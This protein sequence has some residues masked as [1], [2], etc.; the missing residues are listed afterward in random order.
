MASTSGSG[1][2]WRRLCFMMSDQV[3]VD[4]KHASASNQDRSG[5][6]PYETAPARR[7]R[8]GPGVG[9]G[10]PVGVRVCVHEEPAEIDAWV[11]DGP[12]LPVDECPDGGS[13]GKH[14]AQT[15][16]TVDD[17]ARQR[18]RLQGP[19]SGRDV[20]PAR[21]QRCI[22]RLEKAAPAVALLGQA[23]DG[24]ADQPDGIGIESM[25]GRH[26][27]SGVP[28]PLGHGGDVLVTVEIE[29][30]LERCA[31]DERHHEERRHFGWFPCVLPEH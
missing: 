7:G 19:K 28:H 22:N 24:L 23:D 8:E 20:F 5:T 2:V 30:R 16:V 11:A 9:G 15:E 25:Q 3:A 27:P 21:R 6:S 4:L 12:D 14:V 1:W 10:P 26:H 13:G 18:R 29:Q 17:G 31:L